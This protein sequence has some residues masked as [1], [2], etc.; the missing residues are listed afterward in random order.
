MKCL[1]N[2]IEIKWYVYVIAIAIIILLIYI[3]FNK[4][5]SNV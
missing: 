3:G 4:G 5:I 2:I 1:I